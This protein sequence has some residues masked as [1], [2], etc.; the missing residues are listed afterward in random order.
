MTLENRISKLDTI[1]SN[2]HINLITVYVRKNIIEIH[3][4]QYGQEMH[5][6]AGKTYKDI[7]DDLNIRFNAKSEGNHIIVFQERD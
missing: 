7:I 4:D 5:D 3:S 6:R 2:S 1:T